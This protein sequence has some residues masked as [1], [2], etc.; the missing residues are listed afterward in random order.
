MLQYHKSRLLILDQKILSCDI[1]LHS[2]YIEFY[3]I[4]SRLTSENDAKLMQWSQVFAISFYYRHS[5]SIKLRCSYHIFERWTRHTY[6]MW[7][8]HKQILFSI[9]DDAKTLT[10]ILAH[11]RLHTII[12]DE[13]SWIAHWRTFCSMWRC[14]ATLFA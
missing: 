1:F 13:I 3:N 5:H 9:D 7:R 4:L 8:T 2:C 6:M 12:R 11:R 14:D 10:Q